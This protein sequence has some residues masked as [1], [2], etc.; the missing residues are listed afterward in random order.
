M[1]ILRHP[2][3]L[4]SPAPYSTLLISVR[5]GVKEQEGICRVVK[6]KVDEFR[7]SSHSSCQLADTITKESGNEVSWGDGGVEV[8]IREEG[9]CQEGQMNV[10]V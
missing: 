4:L 9:T 2:L 1:L 5:T 10:G 8:V 6:Y 3:A 7:L